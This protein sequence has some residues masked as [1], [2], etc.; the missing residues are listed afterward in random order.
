MRR[1]PT[2]GRGRTVPL[3]RAGFV[4]LPA[5]LLIAVAG[6]GGETMQ[7]QEDP[8]WHIDRIDQRDLPLDDEYRYAATGEGVR[9][10]VVDD[11]IHPNA[12]FAERLE[13]GLRLHGSDPTGDHGTRAAGAAAGTRYGVA[14]GATVVDV[15]AYEDP[16]DDRDH[17]AATAQ[18]YE[19]IVDRHPR[20]TPGVVVNAWGLTDD[21]RVS[22]AVRA[23]LDAGLSL[24]QSAGNLDEAVGEPGALPLPDVERNPE[25]IVVGATTD[26]D[27]R[28]RRSSYG[29]HVDIYAPGAELTLPSKDGRETASGTSGTSWSAPIV[30]G[31]VAM[32]LE[33]DGDLT[34]A[35]VKEALLDRA[36][37]GAITGLPPGSHNLLVYSLRE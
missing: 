10:Y 5:A 24:V 27:E 6:C 22:T 29:P 32:M 20:G 15:H 9:I 34:P 28:W 1:L 4:G 35:E 17:E 37:S 26:Q 30:A 21:E 16:P 14:K 36:T 13:S 7:V 31:I 19:W 25:I 2:H 12:D 3:A 18:A 8:E 11:G 23:L 33:A